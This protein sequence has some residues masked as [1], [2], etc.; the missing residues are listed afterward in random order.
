MGSCIST[1]VSSTKSLLGPIRR[2]G[3]LTG[4][5]LGF[6]AAG[7][8]STGGVTTA[9]DA[10][11]LRAVRFGS[12]ATGVCADAVRDTGATGAAALVSTCTMTGAFSASVVW[13]SKAVWVKRLARWVGAG[14]SGMSEGLL[15]SEKI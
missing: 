9:L 7:A 13:A 5:K 8:V 10:L 14:G 15:I 2:L 12:V 6:V 1:L 4:A 3:R 11:R